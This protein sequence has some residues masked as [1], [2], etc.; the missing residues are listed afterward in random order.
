[1]SDAIAHIKV[2]C[3]AQGLSVYVVPSMGDLPA[4]VKNKLADKETPGA[5]Y[6]GDAIYLVADA[7]ADGAEAESILASRLVRHMTLASLTGDEWPLIVEKI[8]RL[9]ARV[10]P[11]TGWL[12]EAAW[13]RYGRHSHIFGTEEEVRELLTVAVEMRMAEGP[14]ASLLRRFREAISETLQRL[15]FKHRLD[16]VDLDRIITT[17]EEAIKSDKEQGIVQVGDGVPGF[18]V[19]T[20]FPEE[21]SDVETAQIHQRESI[22]K[23]KPT[24]G[25]QL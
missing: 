25:L 14:I 3:E 5:A 22:S 18:A 7:L 4:I 23:A 17:A 21:M 15:G 11:Q 8:Q 19:V 20:D 2:H 13:R 12:A 1:L 16:T 10:D 9:K 6:V 24:T